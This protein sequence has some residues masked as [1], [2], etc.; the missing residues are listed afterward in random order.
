MEDLVAELSSAFLS[1]DLGITPEV[2][3]D[4]AGYI[5][6]WLKV[7]KNDNKAIFSAAGYASK[8]TEFLHGLQP[9]IGRLIVRRRLSAANS[10]LFRQLRPGDGTDARQ[11]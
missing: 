2:R 4:H 3:E 11:G 9:G 6:H 10:L 5:H 1:A 7:L 8:A